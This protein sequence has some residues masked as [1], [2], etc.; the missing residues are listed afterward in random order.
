[1]YIFLAA[2]FISISAVAAE[3]K[4]VAVFEP[5][6]DASNSIKEIVREMISSVIVNTSGFTVLERQ[7]I[8][9]V[10]E[11][12]RFQIGGLVDDDQIVELG[13]LWAPTLPS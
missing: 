9:K 13:R 3:D 10:L 2:M 1:M 11:E 7:L 6:G 5:A 12:Q 8:N 4:K